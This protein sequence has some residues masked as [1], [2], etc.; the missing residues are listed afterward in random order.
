MAE[1]PTYCLKISWKW[2]ATLIFFT[3]S[4]LFFY[5]FCREQIIYHEQ[6]QL[7]Q[8]NLAYLLRLT[9]IPGGISQYI[10]AFF[11]QFF[12]YAWTGALIFTFFVFAVFFA[13]NLIFRHTGISTRFSILP[14]FPAAAYCLMMYDY[15]FNLVWLIS[16]VASL[17][18]FAFYV[19]VF[20]NK[21]SLFFGGLGLV[22]LYFVSPVSMLYSTSL[23]VIY[24]LLF[25][26]K[27]SKYR[28]IAVYM[29][30][31]IILPV[32][33][34][35][36]IFVATPFDTYLTGFPD[37]ETAWTLFLT[38]FAWIFA[39]VMMLLVYCFSFFSNE[40]TKKYYKTPVI[41][42]AILIVFI[43]LSLHHVIDKRIPMMLRMN[44]EVNR[45]NWTETLR[46]SRNYPTGNH[47]VAY[48]T[49]L[50]LHKTGQMFS[51]FFDYR[52]T[53]PSGLI[54][55]WRLDFLTAMA[56]GEVFYHLGFTNEANRWA[57]EALVAS[58]SG[59]NPILLKRL[60]K[61][62]I[63]NENYAIAEK[64]L[65]IL[66]Q[67]LFYK[68]WAKKYLEILNDSD[69]IDNL[70]WVS[71]K[72]SQWIEDD[73]LSGR[74]A[75]ANLPLFFNQN[76]DNKMAFEYLMMYYLL[77]KNIDEFMKN[78]DRVADYDYTAMPPI[79]EEVVLIYLNMQDAELEEYMRY[80]IKAES[81]ERFYEYVQIFQQLANNP[82]LQRREL[83]R[84]FGNT[85]WYYLHFFNQPAI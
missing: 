69:K 39:P 58:K 27:S 28:Q 2:A 71:Q 13:V 66:K 23:I 4:F 10:S 54:L 31:A 84:K 35:R 57:F 78:I 16:F 70:T 73:F 59:E 15:K 68:K 77:T 50:A 49:N 79:F 85:Y 34:S 53:G 52:Q 32:L 8:Y 46:I 20:R 51:N 45:E 81:F 48:Y 44:Y 38:S 6:Q 7:F 33:V 83:S 61:T 11:L 12:L 36:T 74:V 17:M 64:Y 3:A 22:A 60:V 24:E 63:I 19:S 14:L 80:P 37:K 18:F 76:P 55:D 56:G 9:A 40:K 5:F 30:I 25:G 67:T 1:L 65:H 82:Q 43:T 47:L 26:K 42:A 41:S 72:R 75:P 21:N 29:S 62:A